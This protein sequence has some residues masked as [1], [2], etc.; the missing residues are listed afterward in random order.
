MNNFLRRYYILVGACL[1]I[2][3]VA[4]L[5]LTFVTDAGAVQIKTVQ[6]GTATFDLDDTVAIVTLGTAVTDQAK[7]MVLLYPRNANSTGNGNRDQNYLFTATFES[8]STILLERAGANGTAGAWAR[9]TWYVVEFTDGINV[10]RGI[11]SFTDTSPV[12]KTITLAQS[13]VPTKTFTLLYGRS[14]LTSRSSGEQF[15]GTCRVIDDATDNKIEINRGVVAT[16]T[17]SITYSYQVV[18]FQKDATVKSG[19]VTIAA[20]SATASDPLSSE[21]FSAISNLNRTFLITQFRGDATGLVGVDGRILVRGV[22][23]T[24]DQLNFARGQASASTET[25]T[26]RWHVVELTDLVSLAQTNLNS[27]SPVPVS[28]GT[29]AVTSVP[30]SSAITFASNSGVNIEATRSIPFFSRSV[31]GTA[32]D[33]W[34]DGNVAGELTGT[35]ITFKRYSATVATEPQTVAS[36]TPQGTTTADWTAVEF[37]PLTITSPNGG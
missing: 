36:F 20:G 21:G 7:T 27:P 12:T 23:G 2:G 30:Q 9:L 25:V 17:K 14:A 10:Q 4:G 16:G 22:I 19:E 13:F 3:L 11:S 33:E 18:E 15:Q 24:T 6:T 37:C 31:T 26:V 34:D 32:D 1:G 28:F 29:G 35:G 5:G 8:N